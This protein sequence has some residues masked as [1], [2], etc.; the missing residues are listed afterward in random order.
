MQ[1]KRNLFAA[2][3]VMAGFIAPTVFANEPKF[4]SAKERVNKRYT[5]RSK[6]MPHQGQR[7]IARRK[8]Q[9]NRG[10]RTPD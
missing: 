10:I 3:A 1:F 8:S 2:M 6:Y 5:S 7:E 9:I 4:V